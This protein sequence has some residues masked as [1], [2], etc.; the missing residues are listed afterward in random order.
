MSLISQQCL[1]SHPFYL[2]STEDG[3]WG[4]GDEYAEGVTITEDEM[5]NKLNSLLRTADTIFT[6]T[7]NHWYG[8]D[9]KAALPSVDREYR[10]YNCH[11]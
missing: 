7:A 2:S 3:R 10:Y 6:T 11:L 4:G 5:V 9:T 8:A 1:K